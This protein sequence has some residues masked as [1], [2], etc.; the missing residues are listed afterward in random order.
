MEPIEIP[1][2]LTS[3]MNDFNAFYTSKHKNQKLSWCYGLG[4]V[5]IQYLYLQK[6][7]ISV[8]T[9]MQIAL[10]CAL[11]KYGKK[12]IDSLAG[13]LG[14]DPKNLAYEASGLI[15]NPSFNKNRSPTAGIIIGNFKEELEPATEV[16]INKNFTCSSVKFQTLPMVSRKKKPEDEE[17]EDAINLKKY[18]DMLLQMNITRIMKGRIGNKTTHVWLVSETSKQIEVFKA[19]PQ[20]IKEAIEKLIEKNIM[21]RAEND[22]TCYEYVA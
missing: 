2:I 22:R 21:K 10:L 16:D 7:Y 20:Q 8:S 12:T 4:T 14:V 18:Q 13:I 3:C 5:E 9:L 15:F 17:K 6:K 1:K 11:E 19:Q